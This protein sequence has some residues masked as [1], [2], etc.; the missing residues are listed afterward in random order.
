MGRVYFAKFGEEN[1]QAFPHLR[2]TNVLDLPIR[3]VDFSTPADVARHD[4]MVALV[5]EML[6][7]HKRLAA[8]KS[9]ADRTPL[10]RAIEY[11]DGK[12]DELVWELYGLTRED[13]EVIGVLGGGE[14]STDK[15]LFFDLLGK[16]T[17]PVGEEEA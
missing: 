11:T 17:Q 13:K 15:S 12:I 3:R 8:A 4:N 9:D 7:L 16:A 6:A 5:E 14:I 1:K 2:Q 10:E